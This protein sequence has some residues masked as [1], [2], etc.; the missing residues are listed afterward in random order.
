LLIVV[1]K[2]GKWV[3][4]GMS[5]FLVGLCAYEGANYPAL[6]A[7]YPVLNV[8]T[9][10]LSGLGMGLLDL[11]A[12]VTFPNG[13]FG[14]RWILGFH[15]VHSVAVVLFA[16]L[17]TPVFFLINT[18]FTLLSFPLIVGVLIYRSRRLLNL[19]E[20]ATTRWISVSL[21]LY[22]LIILLVFL[23]LPALA[24]E[25]SPALLTAFLAVLYIGMI[26]GSQL[27][28]A[29]FSPQVVQYPLLLVGSTLVIVALF[30]PLRRCIQV[31]IDRSFY[32]RKL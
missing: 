5:A 27:V 15:V 17:T 28:F 12:L 25:D 3:P 11:Y 30:Q 1:K 8:P 24:Q 32:R 20:R 29:T 23:L 22:I 31:M 9:Q 18:M 26:V 6:A 4:L 16:F 21:S 19:K 14:S 10:L 7:A 2:P 13:K